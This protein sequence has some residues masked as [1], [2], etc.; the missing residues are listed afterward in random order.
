MGVPGRI[1]EGG[2]GEEELKNRERTVQCRGEI[3][4]I[5]KRG[6]CSPSGR[7][8]GKKETRFS[9]YSDSSEL[10]RMME[11]IC[12]FQRRPV[13][14]GGAAADVGVGGGRYKCSRQDKA[15]KSPQTV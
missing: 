13:A 15:R 3:I 5:Y 7:L 10:P 12:M 2:G 8:V 1:R 11:A 6:F 9:F 4:T 14:R